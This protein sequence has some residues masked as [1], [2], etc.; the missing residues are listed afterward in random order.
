MDVIGH[1]APRQQAI[2]LAVEV[3]ESLSDSG[4]DARVTKVTTANPAIEA[5][6]RLFQ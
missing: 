2:A 1:H 6:F 4:G 5:S 3:A